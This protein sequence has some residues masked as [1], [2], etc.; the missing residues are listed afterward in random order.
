MSSNIDYTFVKKEN[1][2]ITM[3]STVNSFGLD[4]VTE[5]DFTSFYTNFSDYSYFD[6]GLLPLDGTGLLSLRK[7]AEHVQITYQIKPGI[8]YINWGDHEGDHNAS[9]YY[10]AQPYRIIIADI[11]NG[12]LLGARTFYSPYPITHHDIPLYHV[13]LPNINCKGYRGNGVGWICLYH[14]HDISSFPFNEKVNHI[15]QR[16]SGVETYNDAN[17]SETDGPRFYQEFYD[18]NEDYAYIWNP[19]KWQEVSESSGYE[20][21]LDPDLWIPIKVKDIDDQGSHYPEGVPLTLYMAMLGNYQAYYTDPLMPKPVNAIARGLIEDSSKIFRTFIKSY[22]NSSSLPSPSNPYLSAT[23]VRED[24]SNLKVH[25]PLT[26]HHSEGGEELDEDH[27]ICPSCGNES[28]LD[29]TSTTD[30][31]LVFCDDCFNEKYVFIELTDKYVSSDSP[32][33]Y[34]SELLEVHFDITDHTEEELVQCSSCDYYH[35]VNV[36][37]ILHEHLPIWNSLVE[38][39]SQICNICLSKSASQNATLCSCC[40]GVYIPSSEYNVKQVFDYVS[41]E[42]KPVCNY[43]YYIRY[44][45]VYHTH[46]QEIYCICGKPCSSIEPLSNKHYLHYTASFKYIQEVY[47]EIHNA[48]DYTSYRIF[49]NTLLQTP[50]LFSNQPV[51]LP[52]LESTK[53][54]SFIDNFK[55]KNISYHFHGLCQECLDDSADALNYDSNNLIPHWSKPHQYIMEKMFYNYSLDKEEYLQKLKRCPSITFTIQ[56]IS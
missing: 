32:N 16:C 53:D 27:I 51:S 54:Y 11:V 21:T 23:S 44:N 3:K 20:W 4:S 56:N 43:C 31:N 14:T 22:N 8:Y 19:Q 49:Y 13:N 40:K 2:T 1:G 12:N 30:D 24:L 5:K 34:Y 6:S 35:L 39:T 48:I 33:L 29:Y 36:H 18:D 46:H 52:I 28:H 47:T 9:S 15:I 45:D 26:T 41:L 10:L 38:P 42:Y 25:S 55:T 37:D 17:M 50:S 7:A